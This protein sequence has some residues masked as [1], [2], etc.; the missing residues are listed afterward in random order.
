MKVSRG[1]MLAI[2]ET[3]VASCGKRFGGGIGKI[4]EGKE[5]F[6]LALIRRFNTSLTAPL[7]DDTRRTDCYAGVTIEMF[8]ARKI[9]VIGNWTQTNCVK[10]ARKHMGY[11]R[12]AFYPVPENS[13]FRELKSCMNN[14][15]SK[16]FYQQNVLQSIN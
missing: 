10:V 16:P 3:S 11:S 8:Y 13:H 14:F 6:V 7:L 4:V 5:L 1:E 2:I 15:L 12:K 9:T